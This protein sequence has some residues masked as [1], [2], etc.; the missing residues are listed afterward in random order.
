MLNEIWLKKEKE[1]SLNP[2]GFGAPT[3]NGLPC[4]MH[5][6]AWLKGRLRWRSA[7]RGLFCSW[8][9]LPFSGYRWVRWQVGF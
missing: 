2:A 9:P 3:E 7:A 8:L 6:K 1:S 5:G 4:Q